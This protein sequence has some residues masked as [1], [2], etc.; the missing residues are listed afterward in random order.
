M[1][2]LDSSYSVMVISLGISSS[3]SF[4]VAPVSQISSELIVATFI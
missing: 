3:S 4:H 1:L 2:T